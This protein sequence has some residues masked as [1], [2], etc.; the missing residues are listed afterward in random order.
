MCLELVAIP[1]EASQ[2]S[3]RAVA[4][5]SGLTVTS[6]DR[7]SKGALQFGQDRGCSC[8][9]LADEADWS[10]PVWALDPRVLEGLARAVEF[11]AGRA[12]GVRFQALWVGETAESHER[13]S[14]EELLRTIRANA[15]RNKHVY[16]VGGA[17]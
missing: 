4:D 7:P 5:A 9:L 1:A 2:L 14:L 17:G 15:V 3:T 16:L 11:I 12:K 6:S 13:I 8:S 10:H